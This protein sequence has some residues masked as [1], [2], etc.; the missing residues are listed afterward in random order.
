MEFTDT[1]CHL[2][3]ADY[4]LDPDQV[5]QDAFEEKVTRV[6]AVGCTLEDSKAAVEFAARHDNVWA[7]IGLHPHEAGRYIHDHHALQEFREL[8]SRPK[9]VAVGETGLDFY[10]N[11]SPKEAQV[12]LLRFQLDV[13]ATH[14]LPLIFHVRDAFDDFWPIFDEFHGV[15]RL[16]GV[17]HSFSSDQADLEQIILRDLYVGLNGIMTFTTKPEQLAA[18]KAVPLDRLLLETDAPFLTP[19]PFR[20]KVGEP[21]YVRVTG[22][23]LAHLRGENLESLAITTTA[24]AC[25][26]FKLV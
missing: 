9:V 1:H 8:A 13:A 26:L 12:Q 15:G 25:E 22:E 4:P 19:K 7:A 17:I 11:H 18:A 24:N 21:K 6:I 3:F 16:R 14:N 20:G 23:F 2:Q 5:L 10:Y